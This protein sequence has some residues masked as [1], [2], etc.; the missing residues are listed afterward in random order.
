M[1][2]LYRRHPGFTLI[3][4]LIVVAII[5]ILAAIAVP[6]FLEAQTRAKVSRA[7][8]DMRTLVTAVE[9]YHIDNNKYPPMEDRGFNATAATQHARVPSYLTTPIS[10]IT[11]IPNDPF[12]KNPD[13]VPAMWPKEV[14][15]RFVYY[16]CV[17]NQ[18][19]YPSAWGG[20]LAQWC[21]GW[22]FYGVGPDGKALQGAR[23]TLLPY[24]ATN[25]TV[26]VG[27]VVRTQ[28]KPDG[29]PPHPT[30]NNYLW[31]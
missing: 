31:P 9:S 25:G 10:Y 18:K 16:D 24:D 26:S 21:G 3:E 8:A 27:N 5:A 6:N 22:L 29:I 20:T 7:S 14:G 11:S 30:T 23:A 19:F 12:L 13:A 28:K 4:L 1:F 17:Q 2:T 15:L